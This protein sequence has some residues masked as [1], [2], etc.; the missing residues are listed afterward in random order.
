MSDLPSPNNPAF[1]NVSFEPPWWCRNRHIQ[2]LLPLLRVWP[3]PGYQ[4]EVVDLPDGDF[5]D[6]DW[7]HSGIN[8]SAP[9]SVA[10]LIH[11]L[12]GSS[13]SS[14]IRSLAQSLQKNKITTVAINLRG[15]S[16]RI[17][18]RAKTYHSGHTQDIAFIYNKI[19]KRYPSASI[20]IVGFSLGGNALLKWLGEESTDIELDA[21]V[22]V[23]VPFQLAEAAEYMKHGFS[24]IYQN[25]LVKSLR[26]SLYS[27]YTLFQGRIC[28]SRLAEHIDFPSFD[29][30]I[31]AAIN[32]FRNGKDYYESSSCR[33]Y[34]KNI[35]VP[36]LIIHAQDD[37]F[38]PTTAHP[39]KSDLSKSIIFSLQASGGHVGFVTS[40]L[41]RKTWLN[42]SIISFVVNQEII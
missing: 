42:Q 35:S 37:P 3:K 12:S 29:H 36:T 1:T 39:S 27:R 32:G 8:V 31:T 16:G 5:I 23:S 4:R 38:M 34:L 6:L 41:E 30:N 2:T 21:A 18:R 22:A 9:Q 7:L 13:R 19:K 24:R 20:F 25:K 17:N 26:E 15:C 11:G 40:I 33:Q 10:I 28:L 14:Y